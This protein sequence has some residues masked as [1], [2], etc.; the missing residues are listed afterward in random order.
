L[1]PVINLIAGRNTLPPP[2]RL[3]EP[4]AVTPFFEISAEGFLLRTPSGGRLHY[5]PT[6]GLSLVPPPGR[7]DEDLAPFVSTTIFGAAAWIA[8]QIPLDANAL[9]LPDGRLLLIAGAGEER[10]EELTAALAD[11]FGTAA[12]I[13]PVV[14]LPEGPARCSTN[15]AP[16]SLKT[17]SLH[18][19]KDVISAAAGAPLRP[20]ATRFRVEMPVIDGQAIHRCAGVICIKNIFMGERQ[21]ET[22]SSLE[23][24]KVLRKHIFLPVVG[25]AIWG[26]EVL[27]AALMLVANLMPVLHLSLPR[28][29]PPSREMV[30]WLIG[31]Q[32]LWSEE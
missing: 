24:M 2:D 4:A 32:H 16:M 11:A 28:H 31:K 13:A 30:D 1:E 15:G 27:A 7:T 14:I 21:I 3:T 12:A 29:V 25:K 22:L 26:R 19:L 23:A 6:A 8:G 5:S 18:V 9:Q 20:G 17:E 10:G